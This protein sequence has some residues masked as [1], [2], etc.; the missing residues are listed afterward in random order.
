L[1]FQGWNLLDYDSGNSYDG[2]VVEVNVDGQTNHYDATSG[3]VNGP[4]DELASGS[5]NP[6]AGYRAFAR[7]SHGWVRSRYDLSQWAGHSI[8]PRFLLATDADPVGYDFSLIGWYL[9]DI[10]IYSCN[11]L[12]AMVRGVTVDG[13]ISGMTVQW[14][15]PAANPQGVTAYNVGVQ[16]CPAYSKTVPPTATS[17]RLVISSQLCGGVLEVTIWPTMNSPQGVTPVTVTVRLGMTGAHAR[18]I[19]SHVRFRGVVA[20]V[21]GHR[22]AGGQVRISRKTATGW[23][24]VRTVTTASNGA[25]STTITRR[26]PAYYRVAYLGGPFLIGSHHKDIRL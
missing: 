10:T 25:Y 19:G 8:T 4:T 17:T 18:R 7:D 26:K 24:V 13:F 23:V 12:P 1:S 5:G 11:P 2:G 16:P 15:P 21:D 3:W 6:R 20:T 14:A 9:D 22:V